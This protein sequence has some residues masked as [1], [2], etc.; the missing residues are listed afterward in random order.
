[1]VRNLLENDW[2]SPRKF[3]K[4]YCPDSI[5]HMMMLIATLHSVSPLQL[6]FGWASSH[7]RLGITNPIFN[8][9]HGALFNSFPM[10]SFC[11]FPHRKLILF[12]KVS[13]FL[14]LHR[15]MPHA[16]SP[17]YANYSI[18]TQNHPL[19]LCSVVHSARSIVHGR[20]G[21]SHKHCY[22]RASIQLVSH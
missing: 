20:S 18:V 15:G 21:N 1:M 7:G 14:C 6:S 11:N 10:A 12:A 3:S 19:H 16:L 17:H 13:S 5:V 22:F 9:S 4:Q 8:I 2:K